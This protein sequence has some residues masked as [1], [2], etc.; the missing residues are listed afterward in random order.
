[1]T[2]FNELIKNLP[3]MIDPEE[4]KGLTGRVQFS[5]SGEG[6]GDGVWFWMTARLALAKEQ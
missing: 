2:D 4:A 6:G 5:L 3:K 1:M